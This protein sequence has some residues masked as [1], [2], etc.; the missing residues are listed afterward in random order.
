MIHPHAAADIFLA[1]LHR[2]FL[3]GGIICGATAL[4]VLPLHLALA[5]PPHAAEIL[6]LAWMLSQWPLALYLSQSGNLDRSI[7]LS[8]GIFACFVA[9][10]CAVT[11]GV[12][13]FAAIWLLI[14]PLEAAF[15]TGRKT[16]LGVAVLSG[17]LLTFLAL[18]PFPL[19][20]F[21]PL[22]G[23][24][25]YVA[26]L[27]ALVYTGVLA[28][29]IS[30]DRRRAQAAVQAAEAKRLMISQSVSDIFCEVERDGSVRVMA[31]PVKQ[32]FGAGLSGEE[33]DWL[34]K[35]LHVTDRPLYLTRLSEI[36]HGGPQA[37]FDVRLRVGA[38]SPGETGQVAYRL[39]NLTIRP[40]EHRESDRFEEARPLLLAIRPVDEANGSEHSRSGVATAIRLS[41]GLMEN[42]GRQV[43][44]AFSEIVAQA[45]QIETSCNVLDG[46]AARDAARQVRAAGTAGLECLEAILEPSDNRSGV[47]NEALSGVDLQDC[48]N[49]CAGIVSGLAERKCVAIDFEAEAELPLAEVDERKVR[50][51]LCFLLC[52]LVETAGNGARV[53]VSAS[54][55]KDGLLVALSVRNRQSSLS[56]SA[57][58]SR[59]VL[60]FA[61]ELLERTG[62]ALSVQPVLGHGAN[63]LMRLP[64]RKRSAMSAAPVSSHQQ[65]MLKTA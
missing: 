24:V 55:D 10:V 4:V 6:V 28:L 20:E 58:A 60:D 3:I 15:S 48:F 57:E 17:T 33:G 37:R 41:D 8:S 31:G 14:P 35:R 44:A 22:T 50:Q 29:R 51:A 65:P 59:P 63:L 53:S 52:D 56:W 5:G 46:P 32:I 62:G 38:A 21:G 42:A 39:M 7:A 2:S 47:G 11:G 9:A 12:G 49:R 27:A 43:Q 16:A 54:A 30:A 34:F 36:R 19:P 40:F 25:R 64:V 45:R 13:S 18:N 1:P 61:G 26:A 23:E